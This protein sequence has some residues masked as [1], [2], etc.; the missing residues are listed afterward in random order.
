[1]IC[2]LQDDPVDVAKLTDTI[3][4]A[5]GCRLIPYRDTSGH[6]TI[7]WGINLDAGITLDEAN[8]LLAGRVELAIRQAEIQPW[9]PHVAGNDARA[10][11]FVEILFNVGPGAL[12][13]F[14][15]ALDAAMQ[16]DWAACSAA[17][18]DSLWH[19]QVG[20]RAERICAMILT[21]EDTT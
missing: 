7:G 12:D 8:T 6:L 14:R 15:K 11:A 17:F 21:G 2:A 4:G 20:A 9:W 10:R 18:L 19:R 16:D 5:E 1:M 13:G 3:K